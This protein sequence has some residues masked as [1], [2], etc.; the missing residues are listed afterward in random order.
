MAT[1]VISLLS[2]A[3]AK[4]GE[5]DA[6]VLKS[7]P[8]YS[9]IT[10]SITALGLYD[11]ERRT[12]AVYQVGEENKE[13]NDGDWFYKSRSEKELLED[14]W[15]GAASYDT[16]V[17][18]NGRSFAL[19]FLLHRSVLHEV[20]PSVDIARQRYLTKQ[21]LPYHIDLLD[22][23]TLYGGMSKVKLT[24]FCDLYSIPWPKVGKGKF[25]QVTN[26]TEAITTLYEKWR[27][28]LA[29]RS[30]LNKLEF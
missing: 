11:V 17:T 20:N 10:A 14:F 28:Y 12:G 9:P 18:Y 15:E 3:D 26:E 16:F 5:P 1:L 30:F 4:H 22:E 24:Q 23:L 8:K 29:P 21:I 13:F 27:T 19:P 7:D 2:E 6:P 25:A